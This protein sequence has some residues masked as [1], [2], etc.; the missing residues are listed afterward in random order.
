MPFS[1]HSEQLGGVGY[2]NKL[3]VR[4]IT[5]DGATWTVDNTKGL[6]SF[7]PL[8]ADVELEEVVDADGN[9]HQRC[10][11]G[12]NQY[13][14]KGLHVWNE[15]TGQC[16][17]GASTAADPL[18][19][20]H[21]LLFYELTHISSVF[22]SPAAGGQVVYIESSNAESERLTVA[23]RHSVS[24]RT[25][26]EILRLMLEW[27]IAGSDFGSTEPMASTAT[28]MIAGLAMPDD[29][30]DWIWTNVPPN[31]VQK[32]LQGDTDAQVAETPP[33]ITGTIVEDWLVPLITESPNIGFM[34]TGN[35]S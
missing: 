7:T 28:S 1:E 8:V 31:K 34:P 13:G 3:P 16:N 9:T 22:G 18:T 19:G 17:C 4:T 6:F 14:P 5:Q 23:D 10:D 27:E 29:V 15:I 12:T 30:R 2:Y 25:L 35:G 32:Y 24:A 26:Q 20:S 11:A 21:H 33:D